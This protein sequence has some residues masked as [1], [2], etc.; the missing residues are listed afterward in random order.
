[1]AN[2][3]EIASKSEQLGLLAGAMVDREKRLGAIRECERI[4]LLWTDFTMMY[5]GDFVALWNAFK[6]YK[7]A[8]N[9]EK[10]A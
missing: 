8:K 7:E 5:Q 4:F 1:M 6:R 2:F 3:E 9:R 10:S